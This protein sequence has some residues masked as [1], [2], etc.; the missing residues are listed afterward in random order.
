MFRYEGMTWVLTFLVAGIGL[1]G[2]AGCTSAT[3]GRAAA[4]TDCCG[5]LRSAHPASGRP[6]YALDAVWETDTGRRATLAEL[7]GR[8]QVVAMFYS[9]C[10]IACPVTV[11][12]MKQIESALPPRLRAQVGF[13]LITFDP[14]TDT[15]G[16]LRAFRK[17]QQL[18]DRWTLWRGS[19]MATREVAGQ[20]GVSFERERYRFSHSNQIV[21]LSSQG[22]ILCRL[23]GLRAPLDGL[24]KAAESAVPEP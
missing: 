1:G 3:R 6:V 5:P 20:L 12:R 21:L 2:L 17:A 19:D 23:A 9:S 8:P 18:S 7:Q 22:N 16:T 13:A 10:H 24:V 4:E 14:A 15:P 11:E